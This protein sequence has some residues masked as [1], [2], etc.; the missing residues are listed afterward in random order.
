M[1]V[2]VRYGGLRL[3]EVVRAL[4]GIRYQAAAQAVKR[5]AVS[6]DKDAN[7]R[8]FVMELRRQLSTI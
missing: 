1:H 8:T 6:L 4:K 7:R 2:A 3:A 5:F